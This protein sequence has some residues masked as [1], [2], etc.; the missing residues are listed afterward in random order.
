VN[1]ELVVVDDLTGAFAQQVSAAYQARKGE[2]FSLCLSGGPTARACYERLA[3]DAGEAIDW[4]CVDIYWGDERC[5]PPDD[6]ESNQLLVRQSLLEKVGA[7]NAVYPMRCEEGPE[8]YQLRL[9]E[10]GRLDFVHLGMGADGHTAS[11]FPGSPALEADA[12]QLVALNEDPT[13]RNPYRRMTLTL[14]GIA[15][16]ELVVFTVA[17]EEKRPALEAILAG[18]DL[19]AGRVTAGRVLWLIDRAAAPASLGWPGTSL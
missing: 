9:G 12:G 2:P 6:P 18:E 16:S 1:G 4:W 19:P 7:A 10:V 8:A 13:G 17:G 14:S 11:L 3:A 5:V 15:R